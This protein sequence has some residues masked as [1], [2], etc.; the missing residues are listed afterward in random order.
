[1][2]VRIDRVRMVAKM[3]RKDLTIKRPV[4]ITGL[5]RPTIQSIKGG[6]SC[7]P[8]TANKLAAVLG[9]SIIEKGA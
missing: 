3:T 4:E 2:S 6:K 9:K 7:A 8:E 5:S 1:M